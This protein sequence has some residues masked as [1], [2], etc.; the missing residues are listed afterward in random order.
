MLH[1]NQCWKFRPSIAL[2]MLKCGKERNWQ[3]SSSKTL[4][5]IHMPAND[6]SKVEQH[7]ISYVQ[8][9]LVKVKFLMQC[10]VINL[11][12]FELLSA[13]Q[14]MK[15]WSYFIWWNTLVQ[16]CSLGSEVDNGMPAA[17][18][19]FDLLM[20]DELLVPIGQLKIVWRLPSRLMVF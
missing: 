18:T 16:E 8:L 12:L 20:F 6:L 15:C 19:R 17:F 5:F 9:D 10:Y 4:S 3:I 11:R 14:S 1:L 13:L 7:N 2:V